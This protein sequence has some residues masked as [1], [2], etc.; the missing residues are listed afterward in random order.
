M[1]FSFL[2]VLL[3][4]GCIDE[5]PHNNAVSLSGI[6]VKKLKRPNSKSRCKGFIY[7]VNDYTGL[8]A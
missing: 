1:M 4:P 3:V 2:L 8:Y 5:M 6:E 7:T